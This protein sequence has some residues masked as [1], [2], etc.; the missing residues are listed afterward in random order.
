MRTI[1]I[2]A[3]SATR[4][5]QQIK[6]LPKGLLD[7]NGKTIL[8]RQISFFK[9]NGIDDI[10]II[11]G[12]YNEKFDLNDVRY[13]HDENYDN[14]DVLGSLMVGRQYL[15][16]EVLISYSDILFEEKILQ[17]I[18]D[19][20]TD[21]GIAVDLNWEQNYVGRIE[22]PKSE[23]DNVLI[24]E[25][26]IIKIKKDMSTT[27]K[28]QIMGEFVGLTKLSKHG[29]KIF[30]DKFNQLEKA[31]TGIFHEAPSLEKAYF[32]DMIQ[33]LLD[34]QIKINPILI[35]GKW[36]EI[37]TPQDLQRARELFR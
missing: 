26:K 4:L 10:V 13:V 34:S 20:K 16:G 7:I 32:T 17:Q 2:S 37:D 28:G 15:E 24:F 19:F 33:E 14:H 18:L 31:H 30:V 27:E 3:G 5:G 35:D 12:P 29:A 1:I 6:E 21:I 11:T 8:E 25:N 36:C 23:A 9:K 22:H